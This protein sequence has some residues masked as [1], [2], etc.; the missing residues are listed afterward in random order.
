MC[1]HSEKSLDPIKGILLSLLWFSRSTRLFHT[2][3]DPEHTDP[4][5]DYPPA[6]AKPAILSYEQTIKSGETEYWGND[7]KDENWRSCGRSN[8]RTKD[9]RR[10][11]RLKLDRALAGHPAAPGPR[12]RDGRIEQR[13]KLKFLLGGPPHKIF[14]VNPKQIPSWEQINR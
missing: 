3:A 13:W 2:V 4:D 14:V 6:K 12:N 9:D 7:E 1:P 11:G 5:E 8:Q 10:E